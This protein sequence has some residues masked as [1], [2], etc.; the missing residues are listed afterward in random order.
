MPVARKKGACKPQLERRTP[1]LIRDSGQRL[2]HPESRRICNSACPDPRGGPQPRPPGAMVPPRPSDR[3]EPSAKPPAETMAS[4][5]RLG[6]AMRVVNRHAGASRAPRRRRSH[7]ADSGA[8]H[9]H[10]AAARDAAPSG[11]TPCVYS[12][13]VSLNPWARSQYSTSGNCRV[14]RI[15]PAPLPKW[16]DALPHPSLRQQP[17]VQAARA[18]NRRAHVGEVHVALRRS[19]LT[20]AGWPNVS[21]GTNSCGIRARRG[22]ARSGLH[23]LYTDTVTAESASASCRSAA[24]PDSRSVDNGR[25]VAQDSSTSSSRD[26]SVRASSSRMTVSPC[27]GVLPERFLQVRRPVDDASAVLEGEH[28]DIGRVRR[29]VDPLESPAPARTAGRG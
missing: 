6:T 25:S 23:M 18:D 13:S 21:N 1:L 14:V 4:Q 16:N 20:S 28:L 19:A 5:A 17:L 3:P 7:A 2:A 27:A 12:V 10:A 24:I 26:A 8:G 15:Q 9:D 11:Q 29:D 22:G